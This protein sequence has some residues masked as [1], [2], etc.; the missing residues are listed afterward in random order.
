MARSGSPDQGDW[1]DHALDDW[2]RERPDL[3]TATVGVVGRVGRVAQCLD[4]GLARAFRR[5][6]LTRA[7]FDA[8]AT[9]HRSGPPYCLAQKALMQAL[10]RTS[11]TISVRVDRLER[12]GMV[13]RQPD[14]RDA[15]GSLVALTDKGRRRLDDVLPVHLANE[16]RLLSALTHEER[17]LLAQLL[18]KLLVSFESR[19][20][21][22]SVT[23]ATPEPPS[24]PDQP[25]R[26]R[27]RARP[28]QNSMAPSPRTPF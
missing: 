5:F 4:A 26:P 1:V 19:T 3:D 6:G 11:G 12:Q 25:P 2:A 15:R 16:A 18:R 7:D 10:L 23:P 27:R 22:A 20:G 24:L 13:R 8:L 9:L 14:P 17:D 21:Q 28:S